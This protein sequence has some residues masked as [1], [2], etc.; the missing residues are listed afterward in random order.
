MPV[1]ISFIVPVLNEEESIEALTQKIC[2]NM[3]GAGGDFEI[4]FVDDGSTDN[5]LKTIKK[6]AENNKQVRYISFRKNM[7]K[8]AAL[9]AG[10]RNSRG[11][12]VITMDADLQ[13]DP[14]EIPRFV[15]KINEGFDMVS[16]W[17]YRRRD[18]LEKRLPSKVFNAVISTLSGVKLHD[19]NCGFKAYRREVVESINLYGE[20]HRYIP[21]LA[22]RNGFTVAEIKVKHNK[23]EHGKSKYGFKR[24][25]RGFFDAISVSFLLR[26]ND[27]PMYLFGIFGLFLFIPGI[28]ACLYIT[29]L[30]L[31]GH[32]MTSRPLLI[33]GVLCLI[34][35]M[36][37]FSIGLIGN[38]LVDN[39]SRKN[40]TEW[41]IKEKMTGDK[42]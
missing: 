18:P 11:E 29:I 14:E 32:P 38:M 21:V 4:V 30:W 22:Y 24:Y 12:I 25:L 2:S 7:G 31:G 3:S 17:K 9:Q 39:D 15:E 28:A 20:L 16:G 33:F 23:R 27:K 41:H 5:S 26:Y 8:A 1:Y 19:F 13:D 34:M 35:A 36:Q 40:Y 6:L 42:A 37:M 10:F